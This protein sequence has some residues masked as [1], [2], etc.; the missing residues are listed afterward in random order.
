MSASGAGPFRVDSEVGLLRQVILHRPGLEMLRL[1][2]GNK[3]PP[4]I[5]TSSGTCI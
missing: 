4:S 2:P 1:T 5:A 3:A